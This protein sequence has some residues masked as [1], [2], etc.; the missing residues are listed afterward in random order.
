MFNFL[1]L[2]TIYKKNKWAGFGKKVGAVDKATLTSRC[3]LEI[4]FLDGQNLIRKD[5]QNYLGGYQTL[6]LFYF[7]D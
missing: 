7:G 1:S 4:I 5:G 2:D 6:D 3:F